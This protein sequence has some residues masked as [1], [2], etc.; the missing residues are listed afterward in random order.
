MPLEHTGP[1]RNKSLP[2]RCALFGIGLFAAATVAGIC[3][4]LHLPAPITCAGLAL[5]AVSEW[6]IWRRHLFGAGIEEA[7]CV[8]GLV[9]IA[10]DL[11]GAASGAHEKLAIWLVVGAVAVAGFRVLNALLTTLAALAAS[12]ALYMNLDLVGSTA[13]PAPPDRAMLVSLLCFIGAGLALGAGTRRYARPAHDRM[14]DG[15]V[16]L[17][18][19]A[20]YLWATQSGRFGSPID[21]RLA[22]SLRDWYVPIAPLLMGL[23][24]LAIGIH[25]RTHAPLV[26]A[27]V[28]I[29]CC[30]FELHNSSPLSLEYRLIA[31]GGALLAACYA[32]G[33]Y[34]REGRHG[35]SAVRITQGEPALDVIQQGGAVALGAAQLKPAE[36]GFKG[37]GGQFGGG[38]ASGEF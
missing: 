26:C 7:L 24:A 2:I 14:L 12:V 20:G 33:R 37:G 22:H 19:L 34:L 1:W 16:C 15:L 4:L 13:T 11:S 28:C 6:L 18:P 27:M 5:L 8:V 25:R 9:L 29:G 32:L 31:E 38:G 3:A 23:L 36:P 30:A 21:Y 17:L 35:I 10:V